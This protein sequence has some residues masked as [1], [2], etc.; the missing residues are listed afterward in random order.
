[1]ALSPDCKGLKN[2]PGISLQQKQQAQDEESIILNEMC[3]GSDLFSSH[4]MGLSKNQKHFT[5]WKRHIP[6]NQKVPAH[7]FAL[8]C[9]IRHVCWK[10]KKE[11]SVFSLFHP[12]SSPDKAAY[13]HGALQ[14]EEAKQKDNM[15][16]VTF[17][18]PAPWP[19]QAHP[20]E[21]TSCLE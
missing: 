8:F 1:M 18:S 3:L 21:G 17:G 13:T 6:V 4:T 20:A 19:A 5:R 16:V 9:I 15:S 2:A 11:L 10:E 14:T 12:F 7:L